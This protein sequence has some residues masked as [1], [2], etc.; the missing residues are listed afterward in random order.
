VDPASA[1][2]FNIATFAGNVGLGFVGSNTNAKLEVAGGDIVADNRN[3][4]RVR[5][6]GTSDS[7]RSS[8]GWNSLQLGNNGANYIIAGN[9]A[10]GGS[11]TFV[12]N[13]SNDYTYTTPLPGSI[14]A[15]TIA[16][17][18]N[19]SIPKTVTA[20]S[21]LYSSDRRLKEHIVPIDDSL[22]KIGKI[23]GVTFDWKEGTQNAGKHDVGVIAQ[24]VEQVL[25]EAVH[26]DEKGMKSV[27]YS[28]LVPLLISA[29]NDQQKE[30]QDLKNEIEKLKQK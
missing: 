30:I 21:Y 29:I 9:T 2:K 8:V 12:V 5:Y 1:S 22:L 15:M 25:P 19:I 17:D 18:G 7:Y 26:T 20:F 23:T 4:V 27:D 16:A 11:L 24:D 28:R 3:F 6:S 14:S 10:A 13:A